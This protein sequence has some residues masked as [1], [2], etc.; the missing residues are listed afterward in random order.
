MPPQEFQEYRSRWG[1][2]QA[3]GMLWKMGEGNQKVMQPIR[4][5][6]VTDL[7]QVYGS[8]LKLWLG[9]W[10]EL[11]NS[12]IGKEVQKELL[13]FRGGSTLQA[14]VWDGNRFYTYDLLRL[15]P[16]AQVEITTRQDFLEAV[17]NA[18][19]GEEAFPENYIQ[20]YLRIQK[21][22]ED[23]FDVRLHCNWNTNDLK[24]CELTLLSRLSLVG[25]PQPE[26]GKC[27]S[28]HKHLAF[29]VPLRIRQSHWEVSRAL[30]L[31]PVFGLYYLTDA[32]NKQSYAVAFNQD[33]LL[34]EALKGRLAQ[35]CRL[36]PQSLIF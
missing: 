20:V 15:L 28:K 25:H 26:V 34:L 29:L 36:Q 23:R 11:G 14:A 33:A 3:Q 24:C 17:T 13:R 32:S 31:S 8:K 35:F 9:N 7:Q 1:A 4:E 2:I 12:D 22:V 21:W 10:R 18:G 27:L 5:R 6:M 30:K 16:Y 19:L